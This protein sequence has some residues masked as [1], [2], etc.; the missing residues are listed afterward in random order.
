VFNLLSLLY[1]LIREYYIEWYCLSTVDRQS[2]KLFLVGSIPISALMTLLHKEFK[3]TRNGITEVYITGKLGTKRIIF[4]AST[5]PRESE[6]LEKELIQS[7][8]HGFKEKITL[9]GVGYRAQIVNNM[10]ELSLGYKTPTVIAIP[11][12]IKLSIKG[13][14]T[15]IEGFSTSKRGLRQYLS[16]IVE[17]RPAHKDIY[18]GK[19]IVK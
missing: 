13:G 12:D 19:G 1:I 10:L 9:K 3:L 6:R 8:T 5:S 15:I 14:G 11:S 17:L 16:T 18:T 4:D 2:A 7:V